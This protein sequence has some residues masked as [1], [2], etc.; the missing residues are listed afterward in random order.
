MNM[1]DVIEL[2]ID[3]VSKQYVLKDSW[4]KVIIGEWRQIFMI[5]DEWSSIR[6]RSAA[7]AVMLTG[8]IRN[9]DIFMKMRPSD[10][11]EI[12]SKFEW[13]NN[14]TIE[15]KDSISSEF[16]DI[17]GERYYVLND[18]NNITNVEVE[19][20]EKISSGDSGNFLKFYNLLCT[21]FFRKKVNGIME[22]FHEDFM[23]SRC[24]IFDKCLISDIKSLFFF[25]ENS[26][27]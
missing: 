14:T 16:I 4:D 1:E 2:E 3:G 24:D 13:I 11:N 18:F 15:N 23:K 25:S 5:D 12:E 10:F 6:K 21:V 19:A 26:V 7:V 27:K 9:T 8:D 17:D 20:L 22:D